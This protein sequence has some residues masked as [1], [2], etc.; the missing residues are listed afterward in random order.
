MRHRR[1][2]GVSEANHDPQIGDRDRLLPE[3][4]ATGSADPAAQAEAILAESEQRTLQPERTRRD[5][6]QTPGPSD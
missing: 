2:G 6:T 1:L 5:S 4:L 3:E